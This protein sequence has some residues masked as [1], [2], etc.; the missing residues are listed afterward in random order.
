VS[1][2][3]GLGPFQKECGDCHAIEGLT[4]GGVRDAPGLFAW[5]SPA[6]IARMVRKPGAPDRYGFLAG[7]RKMPAFGT[8]QISDGD[9][10]MVIRYVKG[11]YPGGAACDPPLGPRPLEGTTAGGRAR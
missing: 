7:H 1:D 8:E 11:D 4:E 9:L 10:E 6:W 2:H 3:P 5:A